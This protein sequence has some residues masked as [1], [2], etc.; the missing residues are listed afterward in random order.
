MVETA[1]QSTGRLRVEVAGISVLLLTLMVTT[2]VWV[3]G[4]QA[5]TPPPS[6][7]DIELGNGYFSG[8]Q[9]VPAPDGRMFV[10]EGGG[11]IRVL[12]NDAVLGT[13]LIEIPTTRD[14]GH[15][16]MN[17]ALDDQFADNGHFYAVFS[18]V[19]AD[20]VRTFRLSRFTAT[21]DVASLASEVVLTEDFPDYTSTGLHLGGAMVV[22]SD[23]YIY[24]TTG[25]GVVGA[26]ARELT[27][28]YGKV[29][30]FNK[31]GTIPTSN[32]FYNE[33]TGIYRAI[34]ATGLRSPF[35]LSD[36]Q[37]GSGAIYIG[38]VGEASWEELNE[39]EAGANYG[40]NREEGFGN[41]D[42]LTNPVFA[43]PHPGV[44]PGPLEGC[45]VG[46][47]AFY[48]PE[49]Q[50]FPNDYVGD[51]LLTDVCFGWIGRFDPVSGESEIFAT[52]M[53]QLVDVAVHPL[54]GAIYYLDRDMNGSNR[55][56]IG[57]IDFVDVDQLFISAQPSDT[58]V[59][60]GQTATFSTSAGGPGNITYQ[61]QRNGVRI[62]GATDR[63]FTIPAVSAGDNN[64]V[65]RAVI[66]TEDDVIVTRGAQLIVSDNFA[67]TVAIDDPAPGTTYRAGDTVD[68]SGTGA[69]PEDGALTG[70]SLTWEIRLNHNVHDH[71]FYGPI[72]G[73]NSGS[74][75]LPI[76]DEVDDDVWYTVYLTATDSDGA[77]TTISQRIDPLTSQVTLQTEPEG[78][79]LR[80]DGLVQEG[81]T[82]FTG[83]ERIQREIEAPVTQTQNGVTYEFVSWSDGGA[84]VHGI[85][86]PLD[87]TTYTAIYRVEGGGDATCT[88]NRAG[89]SVTLTFGGML[90]SGR[91][92]LRNGVWLVNVGGVTSYID[93]SAPVGAIYVLRLNGQGI[94]VP[95]ENGG[96]AAT[97][98]ARLL[99][100][101]EVVLSWDPV[102]ESV[103]YVTYRF[104]SGAA[105]FWRG[106]TNAPA[107]TFTEFISDDRTYQYD[108]EAR[109]ASNAV[110]ERIDCDPPLTR[111]PDPVGACSAALVGSTASFSWDPVA[112]AD[113][114][115]IRRNPD[116]IGFFW[117]GRTGAEL[118]AFTDTVA[119]ARS[120]EYRIDARGADGSII[121]SLACAPVLSGGGDGP[122][123]NASLV[124]TTVTVSWSSIATTDRYIV[125]R[126]PDDAQRFW[127]GRRDAPGTTFVDTITDDR[128]YAYDVE[129]RRADGSLI[130]TIVCSP[131]LQR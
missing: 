116:G 6:F 80:L 29:L 98:T 42:G 49:T 111:V 44:Q 53:G 48:N 43:Y 114:Y 13:P 117:R 86:T 61:W 52:D 122:A 94:D 131:D 83:V 84:R 11:R 126:N 109:D 35:S 2:L 31:N 64:D 124:G 5:A 103:K 23:G 91:N 7:T 119:D 123:C 10:V 90:P 38:D 108:V 76:V 8:R 100:D 47:G 65:F 78:L 46:G 110:I 74:V 25:D 125:S 113:H 24:I 89:N 28:L 37:P 45:A 128:R 104:P 73:A 102:A 97:C 120:Y 19:K 54:T 51:F 99:G 18:I 118:L 30:R 16:L 106:A 67:P 59:A 82:T 17:I 107:T 58:S 75:T 33:A 1:R 79:D 85:S 105:R 3:T 71:L 39:L 96:G 68:F 69:D 62:E 72:A 27:N 81:T 26:R 93:A 115:V 57:R 130:Q 66:S 127:R 63:V 121:E 88:A 41:Q 22:G 4:S 12:K 87:D 36:P 55:T 15:G 20:G 112:G 129:A 50:Q 56:G 21:G 40:W 34:Y 14:N 9:L 92:L 60:I 101:G 77:S 70:A 95:C 32:P